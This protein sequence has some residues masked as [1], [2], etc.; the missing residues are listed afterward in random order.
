VKTRGLIGTTLSLFTAAAALALLPDVTLAAGAFNGT[1]KF[2]PDHIQLSKQPIV[3]SLSGG[4]FAC[5][6]C[7]PPIAAAADGLDHTLKGG[8][9]DAVAV[10]VVDAN[11]VQVV[12]KVKGKTMVNMRQSVSSDGTTAVRESTD[13][14]GTSPVVAKFDLKRVAPAPAGAHA[15]SGSWM[16]TKME[17]ISDSGTLETLGDTDD[18]FTFSSNGQSYDAK[19]DGKKVAV[20][21]DPTNTMVSLKRVGPNEVIETDYRKGKTVESIDFKLAANGKTISV[22]D[23]DV[24]E[25]RTDRY[26]LTKQP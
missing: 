14:S 1:W 15:L 7:A 26:K 25:H 3:L 12:L 11:T 2:S 21:G 16:L 13:Y 10:T 22:V 19:F 17:S 18:G 9:Y 4:T 20:A 23:T 6:S 8:P 24:A 5:T